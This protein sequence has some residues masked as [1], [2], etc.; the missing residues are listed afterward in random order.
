MPIDPRIAL[1]VEPGPAPY[2]PGELEQRRLTL[3][4]LGRQ[5][6]LGQQQAELNDMRLAEGKQKQEEYAASVER[7]GRARAVLEKHGGDIEKALPELWSVDPAAADRFETHVFDRKKRDYETRKMEI[8]QAGA[9]SKRLAEIAGTATDQASLRRALGM[10][11]SEKLLSPEQIAAIGDTWD[12]KTAAAVKQFRMQA[13][14]VSKQL[15][16]ARKNDEH[17]WKK[18]EEERKKAA[19]ARTQAVH[20]ATLPSK[21][22]DPKTG[23]TPMQAATV[24]GQEA[25][26]A[27]QAAARSETARHNKAMEEKA[28]RRVASERDATAKADRKEAEKIQQQIDQLQKE[29]RALDSERAGIGQ[30]SK[31]K[32]WQKDEK[33][34]RTKGER[35]FARVTQRLE[36]IK[37][38]EQ[39]L[40]RRKDQL[41]SRSS[42]VTTAEDLFKSYGK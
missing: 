16:E 2:T 13:M 1:G 25:A 40:I 39:E 15:D 10:A 32:A 7:A 34:M 42:T 19:E 20:E 41:Y 23:L 4:S 17:G 11:A 6:Q 31:S 21:K 30:M 22:A 24:K 26:R 27:G 14:D 28:N 37:K 38:D 35:D 36:E 18:A 33:G 8:E 29:K 9:K 3:A 12:E 5:E